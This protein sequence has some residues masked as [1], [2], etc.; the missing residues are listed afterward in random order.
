LDFVADILFANLVRI[1]KDAGLYLPLL[2]GAEEPGKELIDAVESKDFG[3]VQTFESYRSHAAKSSRLSR[4]QQLV[5]Y[6]AR[7]WQNSGELLSKVD[8]K[9]CKFEGAEKKIVAKVLGDVMWYVAGFATLHDLNLDVVA[10]E[11]A[12]KAESM[13]MPKV[14]RKRSPLRDDRCKPHEQFPRKFD[15]DFVSVDANTAIMMINGLQIGD[16]VQDNA[17]QF[18]E[19]VIDG[20]RFHDCIHLAFVAVLG[21]SPVIRGLMKRKRKSD[22]SIDN[23]ED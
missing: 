7:I 13:F 21:W 14:R 17:Y 15:V 1:S 16:R 5:P 8:L 12:Q 23:V 3:L 11:N 4:N 6:L 10:H 20:Y 19:G 9:A 22:A 18:A 2:S